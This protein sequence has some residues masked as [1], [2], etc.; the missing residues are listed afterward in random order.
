MLSSPASD[1]VFC[2]LCSYRSCNVMHRILCKGN[3]KMGCTVVTSLYIKKKKYIKMNK[4]RWS[5]YPLQKSCFVFFSFCHDYGWLVLIWWKA[6]NSLKEMA[7]LYFLNLLCTESVRFFCFSCHGH[8]FTE[9][10]ITIWCFVTTPYDML[11][12]SWGHSV[13]NKHSFP[14]YDK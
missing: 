13:S 8:Q 4:I 14:C 10:E 5:W 7:K 12:W 3:V 6:L 11:T 1:H 2:C 9:A